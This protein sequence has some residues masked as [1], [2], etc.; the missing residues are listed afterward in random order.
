MKAA[1]SNAVTSVVNAVQASATAIGSAVSSAVAPLATSVGEIKD[2]LL[3]A[4][5]PDEKASAIKPSE[6]KLKLQDGDKYIGGGYCPSP[7]SIQFDLAGS[8]VR[9]EFP[10]TPFCDLATMVRPFFVLLGYYLAARIIFRG[11]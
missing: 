5:M 4:D 6:V 1:I 2:F 9:M 10:F 3:S 8:P 7:K 11:E